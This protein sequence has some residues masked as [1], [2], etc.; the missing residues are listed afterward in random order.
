M[1]VPA[2]VVP[3][4]VLVLGGLLLGAG[5]R[6]ARAAAAATIESFAAF[7]A[8]VDPTFVTLRAASRATDARWADLERRHGFGPTPR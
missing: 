1:A 2:V 3:V 6:R 8:A 5:L 4:L 7:R